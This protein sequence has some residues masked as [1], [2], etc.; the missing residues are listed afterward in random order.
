VALPSA[1]GFGIN[2]AAANRLAASNSARTT[3]QCASSANFCEMLN[4]LPLPMN[5]PV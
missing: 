4:F 2:L 1:N 5:L 3:S